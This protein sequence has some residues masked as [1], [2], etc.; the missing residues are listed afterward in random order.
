MWSPAQFARKHTVLLGAVVAVVPLVLL[1][2]FQY[3]WLVRLEETSAIANKA[4]LDHYLEAVTNEV[5]YFY[6]K[7]AERILNL[8][9]SYFSGDNLVSV[10]VSLRKREV[11][12]AKR[13]FFVQYH[14]EGKER[15]YA[16][17]PIAWDIE[18]KP[19][20]EEINA[21]LGALA[22][23]KLLS[24]RRVEVETAH[25]AVD[26]RDPDNR[27]ILNPIIDGEGQVLGVAGLIIDNRFFRKKLLPK[28]V[29]QSLSAYFEHEERALETLIVRVK[30]DQGR[31]MMAT[32]EAE[33]HDNEIRRGFDFIFTD[34]RLEMWS[35]DLTPE[36]WAS[37]NFTL[38]MGL[39]VLL[40]LFLLGGVIL[41]LRMASREMKL[42]RMKG[43]FVSNVSHEL[44]TPLASVR[45]FGE[46][47]RL[48]RVDTKEKVRE[49]GEYIETE[50]RR[51][52]QLINNILD[53]SHIESGR[54]VY[55][56]A[57][58]D[59]HRV[60]E[61][62]LRTFSVRLKHNGF[63]IDTVEPSEPLPAVRLDAQAMVQALAN[64]LDNAVKYSGDS[65]WVGIRLAHENGSVVISV[66]DHGLGISR[67]EQGKIFERFHRISTGLIHDVKGSGL[68]LAIVNHIVQA[69]G[70]HITVD[71]ELGKG[72]TFSIHLP[73][74]TAVHQVREDAE[75]P[76]DSKMGV[77][78][79]A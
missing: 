22:P 9:P 17:D 30:D 4:Y 75:A 70:G 58:G 6:R 33:G 46:F 37:S 52:T 24:E 66:Q 74:E 55:R 64:L 40:A 49:Y 79:H 72:S 67:A 11:E 47:L 7:Q 14:D 2:R 5:E 68:G 48:G 12:G 10:P 51:L 20:Q 27:I 15:L 65:R 13:V 18:S 76:E 26:E 8:P 60:V 16:F 53:F 73:V 77:E 42:S 28:L 19:S 41:A 31:V 1:L 25:L 54:K 38:N 43:E 69:H 56:F 36:Q 34:W 59:I 3:G 45:V 44:R 50:S 62:V 23:W 29:D 21:M 78:S 32:E 71:S 57:S 63:E 35:R 39:S 61:N